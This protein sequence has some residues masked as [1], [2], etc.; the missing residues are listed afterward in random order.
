MVEKEKFHEN[1]FWAGMIF[2]FNNFFR[3][4]FL[5]SETILLVLGVSRSIGKI[6]KVILTR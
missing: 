2:Y 3:K 1:G 5:I 6:F 4:L